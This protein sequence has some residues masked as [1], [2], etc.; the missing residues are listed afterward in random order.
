MPE[1]GLIYFA[2]RNGNYLPGFNENAT[3]PFV[4]GRTY[5][6]RIINMSALAMFNVR[7][8]TL[9][10]GVLAHASSQVYIDGHQMRIIEADGVSSPNLPGQASLTMRRP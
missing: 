1:S 9:V 2:D 8:R 4:P 7:Q 6:L 3:L 10:P 5:R